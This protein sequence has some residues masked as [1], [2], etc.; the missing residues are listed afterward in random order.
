MDFTG[1]R[2]IPNTG[3]DFEIEVEHFQRYLSVKELVK[4]KIVVDAASGAGYGTSILA[5]NASVV[6]GIEISQE[7]VKFSSE[8]YDSPNLQYI[9][10]SID[11][12]PF[13]DNSV[14]VFVSFETI[15]HVSEEI[16]QKFLREIRRVLQSDG[17]LVISSPDKLIYSDHLNYR[18]E[19]HVKEFYRNEFLDFLGDFFAEIKICDQ[20]FV[21]ASILA[22]GG[23][24][25]LE[26]ID[27]SDFP[28]GKYMIAL[29][30]N[31]EIISEQFSSTVAVDREN[32][33][34]KKIDRVIELQGEI[35]EKNEVITGLEGWVK[36]CRDTIRERDQ[37]LF[38]K[39]N[40]LS[41]VTETLVKKT[42]EIEVLHEKV[43]DAENL[44][45]EERAKRKKTK[46]SLAHIHTT[47]AWKIIQKIYWLK[48][49]IF[50]F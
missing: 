36:K 40:E 12:L 20:S 48:N 11:A 50:P 38:A 30:S 45:F 1:E 31:A 17:M 42:M 34:Q 27:S 7:A 44:L 25:I 46:D 8:Q 10:G 49:K 22:C 21:L 35:V 9:Q 39:D 37:A 14:D 6:Y 15:E 23:T 28:N 16:Q 2:Y 18:N 41:S 29:C 47:R 13:P 26:I 4:G 43:S 3:L 33:Y 24:N 32:L 5:E 19:Y